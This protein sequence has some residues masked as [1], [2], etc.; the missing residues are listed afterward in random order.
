[1]SREKQIDDAAYKLNGNENY[2]T[3]IER[4]AF[5]RGAEWADANPDQ[6]AISKFT[7]N[8][9]DENKRLFHKLME[10]NKVITNDD[11]KL[12]EEVNKGKKK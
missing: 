5:K 8:L 12:L 4:L 2:N 1:M 7:S 6:E 3:L 9:M 10:A 11:A